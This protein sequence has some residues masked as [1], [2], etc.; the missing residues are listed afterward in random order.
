MTLKF[1]LTTTIPAPAASIYNAWLSSKEHALMTESESALASHEP[2]A[3]HKA[4]GDYIWGI[5]IEL[6]P[7]KKIVQSWRTGLFTEQDPDSLIEVLL[8]DKGDATL[9]TLI[10]SEV[11]EQEYHVETGWVEYYFE[12]MKRYFSTKTVQYD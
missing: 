8:E 3:K 10:H 9:L 12:P 6:V 2:G 11:P 4:H 5:N 7:N 1:Q